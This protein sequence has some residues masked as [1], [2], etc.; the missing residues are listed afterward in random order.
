MNSVSLIGRW[1]RDVELRYTQ[2]GRAVVNGTIAV[3]DGSETVAFVPV[4]IWSNTAEA[5]ANHRGKKGDQIGITGRLQSRSY[6]TQEGQKRTVI[7][8]VA[9]RVDFLG[10]G[11]AQ[12][13]TPQAN[14][15][16]EPD[17]ADNDD[18]PFD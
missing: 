1:V 13:H 9:S 3:N 6:T 11:Q 5:V 15:G 4:V 2:S 12:E 7:E 8:V 10:G 16:A 18:V 17:S 14:T